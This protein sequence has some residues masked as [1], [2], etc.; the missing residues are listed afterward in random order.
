M[1]VSTEPENTEGETPERRRREHPARRGG[2]WRHGAAGTMPGGTSGEEIPRPRTSSM[3]EPLR[4][5]RQLIAVYT[6]LG[7]VVTAALVGARVAS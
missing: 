4:Y 5:T 1:M 2:H 7:V 3:A 6:I